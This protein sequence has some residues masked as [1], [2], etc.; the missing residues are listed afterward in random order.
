MARPTVRVEILL[1]TTGAYF[2]RLWTIGVSEIGG[3][4]PIGGD[5]WFDIT[6]RVFSGVIVRGKDQETDEARPGRAEITLDNTDQAFD[7]DYTASPYYGQ[8][9]PG[10]RIR[11]IATVAGVDKTLFTGSADDWQLG[12][13]PGVLQN[14]KLIA[15]DAL[16]DLAAAELDEIAPAHT[17]DLSGARVE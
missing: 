3:P 2:G 9:Q 16:A 1:D 5:S 11:V 4:D 14:V 13:A 10:R 17:G 12:D 7:P 8:I 6:D 15:F